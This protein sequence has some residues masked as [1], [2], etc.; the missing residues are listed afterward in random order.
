M[1]QPTERRR[2]GGGAGGTAVRLESVFA[3]HGGA[4]LGEDGPRGCSNSESTD[5]MHAVCLVDGR[6]SQRKG[7]GI[8]GGD[9]R[10]QGVLRRVGRPPRVFL[11]VY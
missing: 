10:N 11:G 4:G 2:T 9:F 7:S 1:H 3:E 6:N 8:S 5:T